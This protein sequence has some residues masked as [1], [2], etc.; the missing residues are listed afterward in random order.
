MYEDP[1]IVDRDLSVQ[2][3]KLII[4]P[5]S[6]TLSNHA[7]VI[8]IDG[9][10][11]CEGTDIQQ[12]IL[13]SIG[14]SIQ[15]GGVLPR[16][17][18]A[19]RL[20][21]HI[22]ESSGYFIYA[23]TVIKFIDNKDCDPVESLA[24]VMGIASSESSDPDTAPFR[25]LDEI[26][27]Q[28]LSQPLI[29]ADLDLGMSHIEEFL[30]LK[31]GHV[32]LALRGLNSVL[33]IEDDQKIT[34]HH[35]SFRDFLED[36]KRSGIFCV[37][38][39]QQ[40]VNLAR[41]LLQVFSHNKVVLDQVGWKLIHEDYDVDMTTAFAHIASAPASPDLVAHLQHSIRLFYSNLALDAYTTTQTESWI[42]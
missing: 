27:I 5:Y 23:S 15:G 6:Q 32:R 42:G 24:L 11:E 38:A 18:I 10:D 8:V 28:I 9:L 37:K 34:V 19:S 39:D 3:Q 33:R 17:F 40:R 1:A 31:T 12:K 14:Q 25:T 20:E 2:L 29:M 16:F 26:Y 4:E 41:N 21:P 13:Q 7:V 36:P 22:S 35:A 30:Q